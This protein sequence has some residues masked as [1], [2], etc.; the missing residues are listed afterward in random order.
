[1]CSEGG[2]IDQV[3]SFWNSV[4]ERLGFST[5]E[6]IDEQSI[7]EDLKSL[8]GKP[9]KYRPPKTKQ[10]KKKTESTSSTPENK[11]EL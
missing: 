9:K 7:T 11:R 2:I 8:K 4:T 6:D 3:S 1:M 10:P 5:A